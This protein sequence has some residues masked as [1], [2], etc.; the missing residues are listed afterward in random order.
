M[1]VQVLLKG[2]SRRIYIKEAVRAV[3]TTR[4]VRITAY[5]KQRAAAETWLL[6]FDASGSEEPIAQFKDVSG[7]RFAETGLYL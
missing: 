5:G 3:W 1:G 4:E 2:N 7:F 6:L